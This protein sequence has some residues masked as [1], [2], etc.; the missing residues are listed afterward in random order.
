MGIANYQKCRKESEIEV[1]IKKLDL[2]IRPDI[3]TNFGNCLE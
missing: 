2:K 1:I 3:K